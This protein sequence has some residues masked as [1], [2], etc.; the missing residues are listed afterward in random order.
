MED[1]AINEL[2]Q[3]Y[4]KYKALRKAAEVQMKVEQKKTFFRAAFWFYIPFISTF[5]L[6]SYIIYQ[7]Q[8]Q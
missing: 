8:H 5:A 2:K 1:L 4:K 3:D 7:L 6:V